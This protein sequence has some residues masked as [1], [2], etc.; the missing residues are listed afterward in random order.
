MRWNKNKLKQ[1]ER[2]NRWKR[3]K[4]VFE[5]KRTN[6]SN[7]EQSF[8]ERIE[9]RNRQ[10]FNDATDTNTFTKRFLSIFRRKK[11]NAEK[12]VFE[13]KIAKLNEKNPRFVVANAAKVAKSRADLSNNNY[14]LLQS[15]F[16][17]LNNEKKFAENNFV[18]WYKESFTNYFSQKPI[19]KK[20]LD[21]LNEYIYD[22]GL[23]NEDLIANLKMMNKAIFAANDKAKLNLQQ[24]A[25]LNQ[26]LG[27]DKTVLGPDATLYD[28]KTTFYRGGFENTE[29]FTAEETNTLK[30]QFSRY[31]N[32]FVSYDETQFSD[33]NLFSNAKNIYYQ[34]FK[35]NLSKHL[36]WKLLNSWGV[37]SLDDFNNAEALITF[38]V[39]HKD[40]AQAFIFEFPRL[41]Q[42]NL[43]D[44]EYAIEVR[45]AIRAQA[46]QAL[47]II[48][49]S[50]KE[51]EEFAAK[52]QT[53]AN[54][55]KFYLYAMKQHVRALGILSAGQP[56][57]GVYHFSNKVDVWQRY[58]TFYVEPFCHYNL[59]TAKDGG[60]TF[61]LK[62]NAP[63]YALAAYPKTFDLERTINAET[64]YND[65]TNEYK[66]RWENLAPEERVETNAFDKDDNLNVDAWPDVNT[67]LQQLLRDETANNLATKQYFHFQNNV[68]LDNDA[69]RNLKLTNARLAL[70]NTQQEWIY[71][72]FTLYDKD[73]IPSKLIKWRI[74]AT[75]IERNQT[76]A[77]GTIDDFT[78]QRIKIQKLV[79]KDEKDEF[80]KPYQRYIYED[81]APADF[82]RTLN[83][84]GSNGLKIN[85][86]EDTLIAK[87][88]KTKSQSLYDLFSTF[89]GRDKDMPAGVAENN[90]VL[91][92]DGFTYTKAADLAL[93]DSTSNVDDT[94]YKAWKD[95]IED[96]VETKLSKNTV[97]FAKALEKKDTWLTK[98]VPS[99]V[100]QHKN[101]EIVRA[102]SDKKVPENDKNDVAAPEN[103]KNDV[104]TPNIS[105][106]PECM[107]ADFIN[108]YAADA[109]KR[110]QEDKEALDAEKAYFNSDEPNE[111]LAETHAKYAA[112][113]L[114]QEQEDKENLA[115]EK[116]YFDSLNET[117][118]PTPEQ[119]P[120][121]P[122]VFS[123]NDEEI[124]NNALNVNNEIDEIN[125]INDEYP[126]APTEKPAEQELH[127]PAPLELSV[128]FN[129]KNPAYD[130]NV[131]ARIK[132]AY[133]QIMLAKAQIETINDEIKKLVNKL[134]SEQTLTKFVR[135]AN[136]QSRTIYDVK[137]VSQTIAQ[138]ITSAGQKHLQE[139]LNDTNNF[140]Y[141]KLD[142]VEKALFWQAFVQTLLNEQK[143][144]TDFL[145]ETFG[146]D[147]AVIFNNVKSFATLP[148][149]L[150]EQVVFAKYHK[151]IAA[152]FAEA[153]AQL[154]NENAEKAKAEAERLAKEEPAP[155]SKASEI[156]NEAVKTVD[157]LKRENSVRPNVVERKIPQKQKKKSVKL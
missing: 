12:A 106:A 98:T 46:N 65:L 144:S 94:I 123:G 55:D 118:A 74:K 103:T 137:F 132:P 125:E 78:T 150:D 33:E 83:T 30:T 60:I 69:M 136:R 25:L 119:A 134:N 84:N 154:A 135:K 9:K 66:T 58:T 105:S 14:L 5:W 113:A 72:P 40:D 104:S 130:E 35:R 147:Y 44:D 90:I 28:K 18:K 51:R 122:D 11:I 56:I 1:L 61:V 10:L 92:D 121:M 85:N 19:E 32:V 91:T 139:L 100:Y 96:G 155:D 152:L 45:D 17:T 36:N 151:T 38:F 80:G 114:K 43:S 27:G 75:T 31:D 128:D 37:S 70:A 140:N 101:K 39:A 141:T 89:Q 29:L 127:R 57:D 107:S 41:R 117:P 116:A 124:V 97:Y 138:L 111:N 143:F 87:A 2:Q 52:Y 108:K 99:L 73:N 63:W 50:T 129:A 54:A 109:V 49:Q 93:L 145:I 48:K 133:A 95:G 21:E 71:T 82:L 53:A 15:N 24:N 34:L 68:L 148:T 8:A 149:A 79:V 142:Y 131:D 153:D 16:Q 146:E 6:E 115:A 42:S 67:Q 13:T 62:D 156:A 7:L 20:T 4:N 126:S 76:D 59:K 26:I 86:Y 22:G 88:L 3:A 47:K 112:D 77:S 120:E 81:W 64:I 102:E 110:E 23:K 157:A